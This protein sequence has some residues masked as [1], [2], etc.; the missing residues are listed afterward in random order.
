MLVIFSAQRVSCGGHSATSCEDCV[1]GNDASWCNGD[2]KWSNNQCVASEGN[3]IGLNVNSQKGRK[4]LVLGL[5]HLAAL[6]LLYCRFSRLYTFCDL[7]Q[8][9]IFIK[10]SEISPSNFSMKYHNSIWVL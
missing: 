8:H 2:C 7:W 1:H 6:L 5:L 4:V 10:S 3:H 9:V